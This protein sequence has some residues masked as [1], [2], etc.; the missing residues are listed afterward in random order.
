MSFN[1]QRYSKNNSIP[2]PDIVS[3]IL[4]RSTILNTVWIGCIAIA[5]FFLVAS[6][7]MEEIELPPWTTEDFYDAIDEDDPKRVQAY[8]TDSERATKEF[9][10]YYILD[11]ALELERD[12]IVH[13]LLEA[14]AGVNTLSAVQHENEQILDEMLKRGV[15]PRGASLAAEQGN[16]HML[17]MLL[18][19]G[20]TDLSTKR[21]AQSGQIEA[22]KLLL[23]HGAKPEGLGVAILHGHED[24][25]NLL[26]ESG[27]DPNELTQHHLSYFDLNLDVPGKYV[28][29]YLSPLHYAVLIKS[30]KLV[31]MLLDKGADPNVVPDALTL[32]ENRHE[33][34]AWPTVLQTASDPETEDTAIAQLLKD[35]GATIDI[36]SSDEEF[37]LEIDL[38]RAADRWDY[39][40]VVRLLEAGARPC[41]FGSFFY[42]F[43]RR[44]DP[45]IMQAFVETGADPNVFS[46]EFGSTYNPTGL[47]LMNRDEDNFNR[48][49]EAGADIYGLLM[50]AYMKVALVRG[51]NEAIET[52]WNLGFQR[53]YD[54]LYGPVNHGHVHTV[55]FLLSKGVRP[56]ALRPAVK[57]EHKKIV[58]L[59]LDAGAD[60]NQPDEHYD[61]SILEIAIETKNQE[62]ID[63]LK[64]AGASD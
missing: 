33:R 41:G 55:E 53:H 44:Y 35:S 47:T 57:Y 31:K 54:Y 27:A 17:N 56:V 13:L 34:Y 49:V 60:P 48:F 29:E 43:S 11:Y 45:R 23:Q 32:Q 25:A 21:T 37:Q 40:E 16:L 61:Q 6:S 52:L 22:L 38:Y 62:I 8:L 28:T 7:P 64:E 58:K 18:S 4:A 2:N 14:G 26:L 5:S 30:Y 46:D 20:E 36:S 12:Q 59:L 9:L 3:R 42:V 24:A 51:L 50:S 63:M 15:E 39:D 1:E 19:H 10:S